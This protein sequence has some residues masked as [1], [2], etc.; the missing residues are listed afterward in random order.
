MSS[1]Q[2]NAAEA[3]IKR[4]QKNLE[5]FRS[6]LPRVYQVLENLMLTRAELV[7]TPGAKDVDMVVDGKSCYRGL[8]KEYSRDEA[9][10]FLKDNPAD[11]PIKTFAPEWPASYTQD[12]FAVSSMRE[13]LELS[14]VTQ[15]N[16]QGYFR[17]GNFIPCLVILGCGLGYH[18]ETLVERANIL[19]AFVVEREPEKFALSLFTVDWARIC[20]RFQRRGYSINFVIGFESQTSSMEEL[21]GRHL[22]SVVPIYPFL[23]MY[24]NHLADVDLAKTA[25]KVASDVATVVAHWSDYDDQLV[26]LKNTELNTRNGLRYIRNSVCPT[27]RYPLV[28]VGSGPS[29][30]QRVHSLKECRDQVVV[31]SAGT[32]LRVLMA[33]GVKPDLHLELDPGY[34]VY[35]AHS[36]LGQGA[37]KDIPLLTINEVNPLVP[38]L[39]GKTRFYFK[40]DNA[41]PAFLGIADDGFAGCNPTCTNAALAIG[42]SLGFRNIFLFG[43]DYGFES[44][45]KDHASQSVYGKDADSEFA[46][47]TRQRALAR[48]RSVFSVAKV[49][50]GTI[51]TRND[52]FS[53]KRSVEQLLLNLERECPDLRVYNCADGAE[54]E[55]TSWLAED[56]FKLGVQ[57]CESTDTNDLDRRLESLEVELDG[58]TVSRALPALV[59][60]VELQL[61]DL[62]VLV[63]K[64]S[65]GGVRDLGVLANELRLLMTNVSPRKGQ[66]T[67]TPA[68]LM[69]NQLLQ[70]AVLRLVHVGLSHAM[71]C[72][73]SREKVEYLKNWR[74]KVLDMLARWPQHFAR[75]M[76]DTRSAGETPWSRTGINMPEPELDQ[77]R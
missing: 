64:S 60:E 37:L 54:I 16:F 76:L 31:I 52:Y 44:T 74:Q 77:A 72:K 58:C 8:A 20:S 75:V 12:R 33:A 1:D 27:T 70:G 63:R 11:K 28:I 56:Q 6:H 68:Q 71:G 7:V 17:D 15:D 57:N 38:G 67:V 39:F 49:N 30:D 26:R 32:G 36:D 50:G 43:T 35:E 21:L 25:L 62:S 55:G 14:P 51:H 42:Y 24:Y 65:L 5:Y 66:L 2:S 48:K 53:A 41:M 69:A 29:M 22:K 4:K 23:T 40:S 61:T 9:L 73:D 18:I 46:R 3:Y 34:F 47:H 59:H 19:S 45:E 13:I 10:Q